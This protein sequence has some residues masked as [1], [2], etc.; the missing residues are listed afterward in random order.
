MSK[1][2]PKT[3]W[4]L[5]TRIT[6]WGLA[7][8]VILNLFFVEEGSD[9]HDWLGYAATA[10]VVFRFVWGFRGAKLSRFI[11]FPISVGSVFSFLKSGL[12]SEKYEGHNPLA[13]LTYLG[14]WALIIALG[15]TGYMMGTDKYWGDEWLQELHA[16]ISMA[17]QVLIG[18]HLLGVAIDSIR[19][20]R[21]TWLRM[22]TGTNQS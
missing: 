16:Q 19:Y 20:R 1:E 8:C 2:N 15:I 22:I 6:H 18:I 5:P 13:S 3:V 21:K 12:N 14:I 11:S 17:L 7:L 4:D 10:V 9:V